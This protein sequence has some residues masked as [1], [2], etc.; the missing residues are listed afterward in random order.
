LPTVSAEWIFITASITAK[1]KRM[2]RCCDVPSAFMNTD[3]DED[4]LMVLKGELVEMMVQ[5][6]PQIY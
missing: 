4:V 1:E 2:V 5:I 3:G 6:V